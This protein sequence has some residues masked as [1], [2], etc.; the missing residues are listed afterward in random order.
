MTVQL[1]LS[2]A[3]DRGVGLRHDTERRIGARRVHS[4]RAQERRRAVRR[5]ARLR[6]LLFTSLALIVPHQLKQVY[7][8]HR[9]PSGAHVS[10][11]IDS[12]LAVPPELAY[13]GLIR[14]AATL[15]QIDATLIR[16]IMQAESAFDPSAVSRAG[17]LGL[18][19][20]MPDVARAFGVEHP[21]DPRE[22]IMGGARLLRELLDQHHGNV[23]LAVASYNAGPT[24]VATYGGVPPFRETQGYVKKV[25]E[26]IAD[27]R[28]AGNND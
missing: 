8:T 10:T 16:S 11:R 14:E 12:M 27:A 3:H 15:Y 24:A 20:L 7:A 22:N 1:G 5:R 19:Q 28:R 13:E 6:S 18:M 26:L 2:E 21:F 9:L 23:R 17:A 25:T 4:R